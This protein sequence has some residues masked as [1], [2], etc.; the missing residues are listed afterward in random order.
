MAR[1]TDTLRHGGVL[2]WLAGVNAVVF[3]LCTALSFAHFDAV[4]LWLAMSGDPGLLLSRPWTVLTYMFTQ[5]EFFHLLFNMLALLWFGSLLLSR[6]SQLRLAILYI[7]GGLTGAL[8]FL[9][10]V[11][12]SPFGNSQ[13]LI[14]A[15]AAVLSV[16]TVAGLLMGDERLHLFFIGDVKLKW[17]VL[18][19]LVLAFISSGGGSADR[20]MAHVGG[21][22]FGAVWSLVVYVN[23]RKQ[24]APRPLNRHRPTQAGARRVASILEQNRMDRIRLDELLDKIKVSGYESLSR[25]ERAELDEISRRISN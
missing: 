20:G 17:I 8:F 25:K 15:S 16:M 4:R 24:K 23:K 21:V 13:W 11:M 19:M 6:I 18:A 2:L 7:G 5:V 9:L 14:G 12:L 10:S 22:V 1:F 3:V